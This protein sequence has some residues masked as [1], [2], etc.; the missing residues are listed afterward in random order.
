MNKYQRRLVALVTPILVLIPF[1][2]SMWKVTFPNDERTEYL[3]TMATFVTSWIICW[4]MRIEPWKLL[5]N[6]ALLVFVPVL[7]FLSN[8][9]IIGINDS[10]Y[11][12]KWDSFLGWIYLAGFSRII[13]WL[14][15]NF[16]DKP[17]PKK[18]QHVTYLL[19]SAFSTLLLFADNPG[20]STIFEP[21][22][23]PFWFITIII[24]TFVEVFLLS[25]KSA[26]WSNV[27][28]VEYIDVPHK[29]ITKIKEK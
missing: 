13:F 21:E 15:E 3:A 4:L 18:S 12:N 26:I 8:V 17:I 20:L 25:D 10:F 2:W 16:G 5:S 6:K 23:L 29:S 28:E 24:V 27:L 14:M 1:F 9:L 19:I 11:I 22:H 7:G